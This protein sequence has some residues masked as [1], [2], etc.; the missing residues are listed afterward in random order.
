[1]TTGPSQVD[2]RPEPSPGTGTSNRS[3][4]AFRPDIDGLRC[5]AILLVLA[6]HAQLP[7]A[8]AG[9][10]GVD[11]F[12][13]ISGYLITRNLVR[14]AE[15]TDRIDLTNFWARRLRRLVPGLGLVTLVT[16]AAGYWLLPLYSLDAHARAGAASALYVSNL[17]FAVET[18]SYFESGSTPSAFLHT[19]SL[20]VEEQFYI[21]IPIL[22][23]LIAW[24]IRRLRSDRL[25]VSLAVLFGC[26]TVTSFALNIRLS[27]Q[28]NAW[29]FFGLPTR[30]WE[31][32]IAALVA[33]I[34][35]NLLRKS[36]T[37][38][39][40]LSLVS[41]MLLCAALVLV[42]EGGYPGYGALL[43]VSATVGFLVC[44]STTPD[45]FRYSV[46]RLLTWPVFQWVGR[47]SYSW[48]L[49]HWPAIVLLAALT[50]TDT[51]AMRSAAV[52]GS[53]PIAV[54]SYQFL[55]SPVR[56]SRWLSERGWRTF[57]MAAG[58]VAVSLITA[59]VVW[60]GTP[61]EVRSVS[62][63]GG[64]A[65]QRS[66]LTLQERIEEAGAEFSA[67]LKNRCGTDAE[68]AKGR[69]GDI[70][71]VGGSPGGVTKVLLLGDS[72]AGMWRPVADAVAKKKG[73]KLF[74]RHLN[75]CPLFEVAA[76][77]ERT[78]VARAGCVTDRAGTK[79]L[80]DEIQPDVVILSTWSGY[81]DPERADEG[82]PA[83]SGAAK[84]KWAEVATDYYRTIFDLDVRVGLIV[85][86]P[87]LPFHASKCL[88]GKNSV[89]ACA[90]RLADT[91]STNG[92][93]SAVE[94]EAFISLGGT[95]MFESTPRIC[96]AEA[97][98]LEIDGG[99]TYV[100]THHL[101]VDFAAT[102][103]DQLDRFFDVLL[104]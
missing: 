90:V 16:L 9:F 72:H 26:I 58:V 81:F 54:L 45:D 71:C 75:N 104:G 77:G 52:L 6:Y 79:R 30:A 97:C 14:E 76:T 86:N 11:M 21:A 64:V 50:S 70:Y 38:C 74:T 89:E 99:L 33:L 68:R 51:V 32:S 37:I 56:Y 25:R 15:L 102:F 103:H 92:A 66:N 12:F 24:G 88:R 84:A 100:D 60:V 23:G 34:P 46:T 2:D 78:D 10:V 67:Q 94:N 36:R 40:A 48:Y 101:T 20:S 91:Q 31:F 1:M 96:P 59:A 69:G 47:V 41:A 7:R 22:F 87:T 43:P 42:R 85:D 95:A 17:Y 65:G 63:Q 57:G 61:P 49:W 4:S 19:W 35:A 5:V 29:A 13:V 93:F 53:L 98:L 39:I 62:T 82:V 3:P 28:G 80:V 8:S 73:V 18:S 83:D 44:G 27:S 55:E